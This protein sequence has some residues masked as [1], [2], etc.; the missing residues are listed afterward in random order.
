MTSTLASAPRK[1]SGTSAAASK[2]RQAGAASEQKLTSPDRV[3]YP[4]SGIRKADVAAY[5]RAITGWLLPEIVDRPLSIIRCPQG[6]SRQ[7]FFQKHRVAGLKVVDAVPL[8]EESGENAD[9][10]VVRDVAGLMELVQFNTLEFHPWGAR[11][12]NPDVADRM[13][14]DLDPGD[15]VPWSEVVAAAR[16]LHKRLEQMQLVSF[17]RT[18]GGKGLHVVV[19][20]QPGCSWDLVKS[21]AH[22]FA[23]AMVEAEPMRFVASSTKKIRKGRIFIDYLRNSRGA[24]SVASFSLRARTGAPAAMPLRWEELGRVK[25]GD[26]YDIRS[27]LRRAQRLTRHPW[28]DFEAIR[29]DLDQVKQWLG[30]RQQ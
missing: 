14:F 25:R 19:P 26:A 12:Q 21:F 15:G 20:L 27:A 6:I 8:K 28:D 16:L 9:Y 10:L 30:Q 17:V 4:D 7:C 13:V 29:Q 24:T 11:A 22:S 18:T 23:D 5:Y 2:R 1:S 3:V